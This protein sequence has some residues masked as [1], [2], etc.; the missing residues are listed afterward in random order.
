MRICYIGSLVLVATG[1]AARP[2][3]AFDLVFGEHAATLQVGA[4]AP[5]VPEP[6]TMLLLAVGLVAIATRARRR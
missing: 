5:P 3:Y 4:L 1:E 2:G 6:E